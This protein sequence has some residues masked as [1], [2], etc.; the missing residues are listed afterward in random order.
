MPAQVARIAGAA[1]WSASEGAASWHVW[2]HRWRG[3]KFERAFAT[4]G[5]RVIDAVG[6]DELRN[7][8]TMRWSPRPTVR[9]CMQVLRVLLFLV[10]GSAGLTGCV[11]FAVPPTTSSLALTG[12]TSSGARPGVRVEAG[13]SPLQVMPSKLHRSW[14]ATLSGS[15]EHD[16]RDAW[17]LAVAAGPILHPWTARSAQRSDRLLPHLVGRWTTAGYGAAVRATIE[18]AAD[19]TGPF[20]GSD[21]TGALRGE[22]AVGLYVEAGYLREDMRDAWSVALGLTLRLPA[23]AGVA[24]CASF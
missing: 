4:A 3:R 15:Y 21:S 11:P 22:M 10:F 13:L 24:C 20:R 6:F 23:S 7:T 16:Q 1:R 19:V 9:T 17:G 5:G 12:S 8:D 18:R 14:D 2:P